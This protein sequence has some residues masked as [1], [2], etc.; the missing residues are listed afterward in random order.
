MQPNS[1]MIHIALCFNE[2]YTQYATTVVASVI[3]NNITEN[4]RFHLLVDNIAPYNEKEISKWIEGRAQKKV[5]FYHIDKNEF[6]IFPLGEA[7]IN[8]STYFRLVMPKLLDGIDKV[9]YLDCDVIVNSSLKEL[10]D[11]DIENYAL[12]GVRDR[13][14]DYVRVYNRLGYPM[15]DGY[16][17]AGVL[18]INL[19]RWREDD[20]YVKA[21]EIASRM[22]KRLL[23]HDQDIINLV[24]C[25]VRCS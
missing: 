20:I 17:N 6:D 12:A 11:T 8:I 15:Q 21:A 13:I 23:N 16:V 7:Y 4:I 9:L 3:A 5:T 2:T 1:I 19:K 18:L 14:N 10:W 25:S 22:P 24:G